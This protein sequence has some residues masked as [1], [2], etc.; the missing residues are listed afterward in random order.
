MIY[1]QASIPSYAIIG[2]SAFIILAVLLLYILS[3]GKYRDMIKPLKKKTYA[4]LFMLPAG[5]Y[6]MDKI[7]YSYTQRD[8]KLR[9]SFSELYGN[10]HALYYLRVH[11]ANKIAS[12]M[13]FLLFL[14]FFSLYLNIQSINPIDY[15]PLVSINGNLIKRPEFNAN[16]YK[17]DDVKLNV[18]AEITKDDNKEIK[19]Y[20]IKVP[21]QL[22]DDNTCVDL[23]IQDLEENFIK[24][25]RLKFE[26]GISSSLNFQKF[27]Y[28]LGCEIVL[29]T[30]PVQ[31]YLS[32]NG[33]LIQPGADVRQSP[34]LGANLLVSKGDIVK[35]TSEFTIKLFPEIEQINLLDELDRVV[36]DINN[37]TNANEVIEMPHSL[38]S[39]SVSWSQVKEPENNIKYIFFIGG[40]FV[41]A[42]VFALMDSEVDKSIKKKRESI[43]HDFPEFI[44]KYVLL[45]GCGMT[46]Y[47]SF[48]KIIKDN[49]NTANTYEKRP[50]YKELETTLREIDLGKPEIYAYENF[51]LRCRITEAMKFSSLVTQN[52]RRGTDDLLMLLKELVSDVWQVH[53]A[54]IRRKGEEASTKLVFPMILSLVSVL[55]MLIYPAL[56][57]MQL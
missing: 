51:G 43:K 18:Q 8:K 57:S 40:F 29:K 37:N 1:S 27:S 6:L 44:S 11:I 41:V 56:I 32:G 49:V 25:N 24:P 3:R 33:E 21:M 14:S 9:D 16:T 46:T 45:L 12:G 30:E 31:A 35:Q 55:L 26:N 34:I 4:F 47:D 39:A 52:L 48:R 15:E 17:N 19:I 50:I 36:E 7:K 38:E 23:V 13:V 28:R 5:L 20:E 54:E 10:K 42:L 53:K 22:P 2:V